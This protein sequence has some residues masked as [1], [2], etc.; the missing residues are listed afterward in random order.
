MILL[1]A[2]APRSRPGGCTSAA[3]CLCWLMPRQ[4]PALRG[5]LPP[6]PALQSLQM[7]EELRGPFLKAVDRGEI[8][9]MQNKLMAAAPINQARSIKSGPR[10]HP[11]PSSLH[12][13]L[14]SPLSHAR[15]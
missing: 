9:S 14:S 4:S 13:P 3:P 11:L 12:L 2:A 7:P 1:N 8:R 10:A 5:F 6:H 15:I